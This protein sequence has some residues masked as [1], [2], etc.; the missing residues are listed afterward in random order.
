MAEEKQCDLLLGH[1]SVEKE[2]VRILADCLQ[3]EA[4]LKPFLDRWHLIPGEPWQEAMEEALTRSETVAAETIP[5][6]GCETVR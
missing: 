2:A 5:P 6:R 3:E 1:N 4:G